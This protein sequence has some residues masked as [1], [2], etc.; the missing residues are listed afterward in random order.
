MALAHAAASNP[1]GRMRATVVMGFGQRFRSLRHSRG[2]LFS[3]IVSPVIAIGCLAPK[4]PQ[5]PDVLSTASPNP[6]STHKEWSPERAGSHCSFPAEAENLPIDRGIVRITVDVRADGT[7]SSVTVLS[8]PGYGFGEAAKQCA[9]EQ[10]YVA[11]RD[12][13]GRAIASRTKPFSVRFVRAAL[14]AR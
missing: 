2:A 11:A 13:S 12:E 10:R 9:M 3:S 1:S 4:G 6:E 7:P 8:D 14:P 5:R